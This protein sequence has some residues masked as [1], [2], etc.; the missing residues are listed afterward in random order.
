M[1]I[2][3]VRLSL[4]ESFSQVHRSFADEVCSPGIFCVTSYDHL[5]ATFDLER[6]FLDLWRRRWRFTILVGARARFV[7]GVFIDSEANLLVP[8]GMLTAAFDRLRPSP[9]IVEDWPCD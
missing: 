2:R 9:L 1:I 7:I 3:A 6:T 4:S 5:V 8:L